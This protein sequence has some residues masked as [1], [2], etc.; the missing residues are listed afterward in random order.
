MR[1]TSRPNASNPVSARP[2]RCAILF[3]YQDRY[4]QE[5]F[6]GKIGFDQL[7]PERA[8]ALN[9]VETRFK[10]PPD[11][12]DLLIAAGRDAL[13]TNP[14]FNEFLTSLPRAGPAAR[15]R[16]TPVATPDINPHEARA[17]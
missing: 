6:I 4:T 5:F 8:K 7:G 17:Q 12:V 1:S 10:L 9:T 11:Q 2:A 15:P 14:K 13:A 16:A 3:S